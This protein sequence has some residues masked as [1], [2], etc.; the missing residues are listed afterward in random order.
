M[1]LAF[2]FLLLAP[3]APGQISW[4]SQGLALRRW[5]TKDGLPQVSVNALAQTPDGYVWCATFAGLSRFDGS[6]FKTF[7]PTNSGIQ[8]TR[9]TSLGVDRSGALWIGTEEGWVI[10]FREGK[11]ELIAS[12]PKRIWGFAFPPDGVVWL[13]HR[14]SVSRIVNGQ[15]TDIDIGEELA[16]R[17]SISCFRVDNGGAVWVA[18]RRLRRADPRGST[19]ISAADGT[20][21]ET[22][23]T[24]SINVDGRIAVAAANGLFLGRW[25][26]TD[27]A[28]VKVGPP[29]V[30]VHIGSDGL[31]WTDRNNRLHRLVNSQDAAIQIDTG[32]GT[33]WNIAAFITDPDRSVWIG[34]RQHGLVN[35]SVEPFDHIRI[36]ASGASGLSIFPSDSPGTLVIG[37]E[38]G[39]WSFDVRDQSLVRRPEFGPEAVRD[40]IIAHDGSLWVAS[41]ANVLCTTTHTSYTLS[42]TPGYDDL[43]TFSIFESRDH[44]I[45]CGTNA[46]L[47]S[48]PPKSPSFI[49]VTGIVTRVTDSPI[50]TIAEDSAGAIWI[51]NKD[52]LLCLRD[53]KATPIAPPPSIALNNVRTIHV[54]TDDTLWIGTYG[55]GLFRLRNGH[56]ARISTDHGLPDNMVINLQFDS[57]NIIWI[58]TNHGVVRVP[59]ASLEASANSGVPL[60]DAML[61]DS[62]EGNGNSGFIAP[63]GDLYFPTIEGVVHIRR[64]AVA[65]DSPPP[66]IA[67]EAATIDGVPC[68]LVSPLI[69]P[70]ACTRIEFQFASIGF[71]RPEMTRFRYR[72]KGFDPAWVDGGTKRRVTYTNLA[73]GTYQFSVAASNENGTWSDTPAQATITIQPALYQNV[74]FFPALG[75]AAVATALVVHT[76]R[77]RTVRRHARELEQEILRRE[78][79]ETER[80]ELEVALARARKFEAIGTLASGITHD[81]NNILFTVRANAS[82]LRGNPRQTDAIDRIEQAANQAS[83]VVAALRTFSRQGESMQT[84]LDLHA[85]ASDTVKEIRSHLKPQCAIELVAP[86]SE[87][88]LVLGNQTQLKQALANLITNA[89]EAMPG[90][91]TVRVELLRDPSLRNRARIVVVDSGRGIPDTL[92]ERVFDPFFTTKPL[93][94]GTGLGLAIVHG[95]VKDHR[96]SISIGN[97]IGSGTSVA[98]TLPLIPAALLNHAPDPAPPAT[99]NSSHT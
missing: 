62:G 5:T 23:Q 3:E 46:G 73:P 98:I 1:L 77:L 20:P 64:A 56:F 21:I 66:G 71:K 87:P 50:R 10:R 67:L 90:G 51:G 35:I 53:G 29:A 68:P 97:G 32:E 88:L 2:S 47:F 8:S 61:L 48:K 33:H 58:N 49:Q 96:G 94:Q 25:D 79:A 63:S 99:P 55:C 9:L 34:T 39:A 36:P 11:F 43:A 57:Q 4:D 74:W 89:I 65:T 24:I 91:G 42:P 30:S 52:G 76:Y 12:T 14:D 44:T 6:D 80:D 28:F 41:G 81:F 27:H 38:H 16:D 37:A 18:E 31:L 75:A 95:V 13:S 40:G 85:L 84:T 15:V 92:R 93:E 54:D 78:E 19:Y 69:V 82:L 86:G 59:R 83:E 7:D 22:P 72:L 70:P 60:A 26:R 45:W 17:A